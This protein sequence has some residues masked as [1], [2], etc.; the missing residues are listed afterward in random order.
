MPTTKFK[1]EDA[2]VTHP[3]IAD[4]RLNSEPKV[5]YPMYEYIYIEISKSPRTSRMCESSWNYS[6]AWIFHEE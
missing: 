2:G 1:I 4:S 6:N 3:I 5:V